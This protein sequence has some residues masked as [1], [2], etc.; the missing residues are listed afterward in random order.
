MKKS[1]LVLAT[2]LAIPA[3]L[4]S[5][6]KKEAEKPA[7]SSVPAE[8]DPNEVLEGFED[9]TEITIGE[10]YNIAGGLTLEVGVVHKFKGK[11]A[12]GQA[13]DRMLYLSAHGSAISASQHVESKWLDYKGDE[14]PKTEYRWGTYDGWYYFTITKTEADEHTS[15]VENIDMANMDMPISID[16]ST[17]VGKDLSAYGSSWYSFK[18]TAAGDYAIDVTGTGT[19][20]NN[21]RFSIFNS[22]FTQ[23]TVKDDGSYYKYYFT[24]EQAG[25]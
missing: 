23:V 9:A 19:G 7:E 3:L 2:F 4:G 25:L 20:F 13:K 14:L 21:A 22:S 17:T 10:K 16:S 8:K 11:F 15:V 6:G 18:V 1:L 5:C 12:E 24:A